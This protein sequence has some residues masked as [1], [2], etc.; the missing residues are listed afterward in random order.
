M[1]KRSV[2]PPM[3]E[4]PQEFRDR[5]GDRPGRQRAMFAEGHLL[6][7]L[8]LP[9]NAD[10]DHR[11]GRYIWRKPDGTWTSNDLGGGIVALTKHLNEYGEKLQGLDQREEQAKSAADYFL[12]LEQL[13]PLQRSTAN[14][15]TVLQEARKLVP[16]DRNLI[17]VRDQSYDLERTADLLYANTKNALDF[18]MARQAEEESRA[19]RQMAISAHRLNS[20]AAFFFPL[21]TLSAVFGVNMLNGFENVPPPIP[22]VALILIGLAI[23]SALA[24]A[25]NRPTKN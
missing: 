7:V 4:V 18:Q 13:A 9:P 12:V 11:R 20:L 6:L 15:H 1:E 16:D 3:W 5:L 23:G 21:A 17:N 14:L 19:S 22:I 25:I 2:L 24:F 8:H 10:E